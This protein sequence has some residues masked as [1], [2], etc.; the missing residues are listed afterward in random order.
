M[1]LKGPFYKKPSVPYAW[2]CT[3]TPGRICEL[4]ESLIEWVEDQYKNEEQFLFGDW[5]FANKVNPKHLTYIANK[6]ENFK[7]AY[8]LAKAYQEHCICKG[9]LKRS[10]DSSF[11]KFML[12]NH[13]DYT[14][15]AEKDRDNELENDFGHFMKYIKN[16]KKKDG[17]QGTV[18]ETDI[19]SE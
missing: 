10:L 6:S 11:A 15:N 7:N 3:Y 2:G 18:P 14:S 17:S 13:H 12:I 5:A 16:L 19:G 1:N 4:T 9:T 8:L